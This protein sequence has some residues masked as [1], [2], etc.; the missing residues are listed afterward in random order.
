M[1]V[2]LRA[3]PSRRRASSSWFSASRAAPVTASRRDSCDSS[4]STSTPGQRRISPMRSEP[5]PLNVA[6]T[7]DSSAR[8]WS[9]RPWFS[10]SVAP[11]V[12]V[13]CR[14]MRHSS[15]PRDSSPMSISRRAG[16]NARHS[17][18]A[19]N[20]RSRKRELTVR[21]STETEAV[22]PLGSPLAFVSGAWRVARPYPVM[23]WIIVGYLA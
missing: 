15:L 8:I 20:N 6:A 2:A 22:R 10:A 16:S 7:V 11:P 19:R 21:N 14:L 23:L 1:S 5:A 18:G 3:S 13:R 9:S 12:S 17:S 4:G